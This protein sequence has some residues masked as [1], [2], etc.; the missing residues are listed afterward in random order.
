MI[1]SRTFWATILELSKIFLM[2]FWSYN[3]GFFQEYFLRTIIA[4]PNYSKD[5][6]I[7]KS[8]YC[9]KSQF[10]KNIFQQFQ[11]AIQIFYEFLMNFFRHVLAINQI[12]FSNISSRTFLAINL[13][14]FKDILSY[15]PEFIQKTFP[16]EFYSFNPDVRPRTFTDSISFLGIVFEFYSYN[17]DFFPRIFLS[18]RSHNPG[19]FSR[20]FTALIR[21]LEIFFDI[22]S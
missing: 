4:S 20:T 12:P 1:F 3:G 9:F 21:F 11:S 18:S 13:N 14:F 10:F 17:P 8:E 15:N 6:R 16:T 2:D 19:L 7:Y 22:H 5:L